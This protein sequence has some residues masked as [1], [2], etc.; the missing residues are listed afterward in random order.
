[1]KRKGIENGLL[2]NFEPD[3]WLGATQTERADI[4]S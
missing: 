1:L 2:G 4:V 3:E